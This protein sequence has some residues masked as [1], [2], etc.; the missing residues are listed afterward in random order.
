MKYR[1]EGTTLEAVG[2]FVRVTL[3]NGKVSVSEKECPTS[4]EVADML[5]RMQGYY[6]NNAQLQAC[7]RAATDA[8]NNVTELAL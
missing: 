5:C 8:R 3:G 1:L 6:P 7:G 2:T 4:Y